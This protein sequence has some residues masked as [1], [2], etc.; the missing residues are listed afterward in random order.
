MNYPQKSNDIQYVNGI[1]SAKAYNLMPNQTVLLMDSTMSRFYIKTTD[2][3]GF[4]SIKSYDFAEVKEDA[5][6]E[7]VTRSEFEALRSE[8]TA[9][10]DRGNRRKGKENESNINE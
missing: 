1:D 2:A 8:L 3:S 10:L 7:Y 4:A 5:P 6:K 9:L